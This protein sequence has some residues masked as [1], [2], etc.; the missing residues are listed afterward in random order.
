MVSGPTLGLT[1]D[2][3][4]QLVNDSQPIRERRASLAERSP[5]RRTTGRRQGELFLADRTYRG[6]QVGA[7]AGTP[8]DEDRSGARD[9]RRR[10]TA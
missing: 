9:R 10:L 4:V 2:G 6:D 7:G 5:P 3:M 8:L 1:V